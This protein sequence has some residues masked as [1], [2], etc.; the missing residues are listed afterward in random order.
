MT[1][2]VLVH[3]AG[4]GGWCW[5]RVAPLLR[6]AGHE[7]VTPTLTGLGERV[8]L[9]DG[10][11]D[12]ELHVTDI[13]NVLRYEDL[14]DVVLVGHSYGG[15]VITGAADR[16]PERVAKLVYLDAAFP[17]DGQSVADVVE[18]VEG[19]RANG[20]VIDGIELVL[21]PTPV[22]GPFYG[23]TD[24]EERAFMAGRLTAFPWKCFAQP[25]RLTDPARVAA[26]ADF[27]V[28]CRDGASV[29]PPAVEER[30]RAEGRFWEMATNH[31]LMISEPVALADLLREISAR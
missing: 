17:G 1:T 23:V 31:E 15:T 2:F 16:A 18:P 21:L 9:L 20:E 12:L 30:A 26:I 29:L 27:H 14:H 25:L 3:G 28:V 10:R 24:P 19:L 11:V 13:V 5:G 22:G 6:A 8:H 7:V 4:H